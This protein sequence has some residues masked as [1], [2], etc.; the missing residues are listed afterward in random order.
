[1]ELEQIKYQFQELNSQRQ[2]QTSFDIQEVKQLQDDL[3]NY[4]IIAEEQMQIISDY[5]QT[6]NI[7]IDNE[8]DEL[9]KELSNYHK[10]QFDRTSDLHNYVKHSK[11][12]SNNYSQSKITLELLE[13]KLQESRK[14]KKEYFNPN[15]V[16]RPNSTG[17]NNL[18]VLQS[19]IETEGKLKQ[20]LEK[21]KHT[22]SMNNTLKQELGSISDMNEE[23]IEQNQALKQKLKKYHTKCQEL[24]KENNRLIQNFAKIEEELHDMTS[25][26]Q[27]SDLMSNTDQDI[28]KQE[29]LIREYE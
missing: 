4:R 19:D 24:E 26:H 27:K 1:M 8:N 25:R 15:K 13:K 28:L 20:A 17:Q 3:Q 9:E 11:I 21:L 10:N 18:H 14:I 6:V 22:S 2:Q 5:E 23:L 7:N 12:E 29:R 16:M